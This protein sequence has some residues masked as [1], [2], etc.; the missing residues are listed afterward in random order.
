MKVGK[1]R[2]LRG[3]YRSPIEN[4][5]KQ[6]GHGSL[7]FIRLFPDEVGGRH[8]QSN[9]ISPSSV[10]QRFMPNNEQ[11]AVVVF[12]TSAAALVRSAQNTTQLHDLS[13]CQNAFRVVICWGSTPATGTV[14]QKGVYGSQGVMAEICLL[15]RNLHGSSNHIFR[16]F[17]YKRKHRLGNR[18]AAM[19][20]CMRN[21]KLPEMGFHYGSFPSQQQLDLAP[22]PFGIGIRIQ[23]VNPW[24]AIPPKKAPHLCACPWAIQLQW[25]EWQLHLNKVVQVESLMLVVKCWWL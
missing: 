12:L 11:H 17:L 2:G 23:R 16:G 22:W 5:F 15:S 1:K 8:H 19:S 18:N 20:F 24:L 6:K 13:A 7:S 25:W 4:S 3:S 9:L 10:A 14:M 21:P